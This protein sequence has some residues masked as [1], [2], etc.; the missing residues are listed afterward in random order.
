MRRTRRREEGQIQER[1]KGRK[2]LIRWTAQ[3]GARLS[4]I[5]KGDFV[6]AQAALIRELRPSGPVKPER[7]FKS[8]AEVEFAAYVKREWKAST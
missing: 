1:V 4:K 6:E 5:V 7:T 2:Y 3:S 8:Y